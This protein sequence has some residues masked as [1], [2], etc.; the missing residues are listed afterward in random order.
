MHQLP[1]IIADVAREAVEKEQR[2]FAA[3]PANCT[4]RESVRNLEEKFLQYVLLK[5]LVKECA[6]G[7]LKGLKLTAEF[8]RRQS[9]VDFALFEQADDWKHPVALI[10]MKGPHWPRSL[11]EK[12]TEYA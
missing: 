6:H 9:R 11:P 3:L 4:D 2:F 1:Q 8:Q 7:E 12:M 10:E 5:G